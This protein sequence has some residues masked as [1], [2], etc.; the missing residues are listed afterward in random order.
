MRWLLI[1]GII[2]FSPAALA[3]NLN[4]VP[5]DV[6]KG[7]LTKQFMEAPVKRGILNSKEY[8]EIWQTRDGSKFSIVSTN[9]HSMSCLLAWG[10]DI[11]DVVWMDSEGEEAK[12]G[13]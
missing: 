4:C 8:I 5:T 6:I 1:F 13:R 9:I 2:I 11:E 7:Y 12:D 3:H 10:K